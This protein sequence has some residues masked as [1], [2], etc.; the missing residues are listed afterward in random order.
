MITYNN[1]VLKVGSSWLNYEPPV[2]SY[3]L[4]I[5]VNTS[6]LIKTNI[7]ICSLKV[8]GQSA[9]TSEMTQ[10]GSRESSATPYLY[11]ILTN[12]EK[13]QILSTSTYLYKESYGLW[14]HFAYNLLDFSTISFKTTPSTASVTNVELVASLYK[15]VKGGP[16]R[17][18][19]VDQYVYTQRGNTT[20]TL[21]RL[22]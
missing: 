5:D 20:I 14:I 16:A 13:N 1:S 12:A 22:A 7:A 15:A 8:D 11:H 2:Y 18:T 3:E 21:N 6:P 10:A 9:T 17:G 19:L 4:F